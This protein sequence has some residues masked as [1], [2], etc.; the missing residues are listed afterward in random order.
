MVDVGIVDPLLVTKTA[1]NNAVSIAS[2]IG[3]E[4]GNHQE[5]SFEQINK[6]L[7]QLFEARHEQGG[8]LTGIST[9][10]KNLDE[11]F[12]GLQKTDMIVLAGRPGSGKTQLGINILVKAAQ[13]KPSIFF[14]MEMGA[15]Q[16]A[17]RMWSMGG[18]E[19]NNIRR[20]IIDQMNMENLNAQVGKIK[21]LPIIID[22][23]PAL[24]P[25]QVRAKCLIEKKRHGDLGLV[26][27]D[28]IGLMK[29]NDKRASITEQVTQI[30]KSMKALAKE[31]ECPVIALSQLNREC[32]KRPD[33][34]PKLSDLRDSGAIEQD[35]D[36]IWFM[37]RDDYYAEMEKRESEYPNIAEVITAKYRAG[38]CGVDYLKTEFHF[39]RFRDVS[40]NYQHIPHSGEA[41][42]YEF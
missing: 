25:Q 21:D 38:V 15:E 41:K 16:I 4:N 29:V 33:K 2:N 5:R 7:M 18:Y 22:D 14:S 32:E 40:D 17:E 9:G 3:L 28:Y 27:V 37:Y 42:T 19:L 8:A 10:F 1:L 34:R 23:R 35:A 24:T 30:S 39:S 12:N 11:R 20:G 31:L 36:I 6:D 26:V 13:Q